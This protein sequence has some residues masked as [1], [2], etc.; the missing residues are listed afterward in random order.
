M[1]VVSR[2]W[3]NVNQFRCFKDNLWGFYFFIGIKN[4]AKKITAMWHTEFYDM[5]EDALPVGVKA[6]ATVALDFLQR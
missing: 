3:Y 2:I 5:D 4:E 6:M 1:Y